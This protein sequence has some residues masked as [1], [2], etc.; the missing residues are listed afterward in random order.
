M[1]VVIGWEG[2]R[3]DAPHFAAIQSEILRAALSDEAITVHTIGYPGDASE[4]LWQLGERWRIDD[5]GA[6]RDFEILLAPLIRTPLNGAAMS[7]RIL[8]AMR[9]GVP[10][11]ASARWPL[12]SLI[13][14][15]VSGLL[16]PDG[17]DREWNRAILRLAR[18]EQARTEMGGAAAHAAKALG[19]KSGRRGRGGR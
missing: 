3:H 16:I 18:D 13:V 8:A 14:D 6:Q 2:T 5:P 17:R 11:I 1:S 7:G 10:V 4:P 12:R 9:T 15:G 19:G